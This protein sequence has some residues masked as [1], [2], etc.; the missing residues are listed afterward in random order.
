MEEGR[1]GAGKKGKSFWGFGGVAR[2]SDGVVGTQGFQCRGWLRGGG[3][4]LPMGDGRGDLFQQG[5]VRQSNH[6]FN[7]LI[8][9]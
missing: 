1:R 9:I 5:R 8:P 3:G 2:G 4:F 7:D 6:W